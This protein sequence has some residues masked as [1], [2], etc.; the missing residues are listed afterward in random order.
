MIYSA[1]RYVLW[2]YIEG[3]AETRQFVL[4]RRRGAFLVS[5]YKETRF[6]GMCQNMERIKHVR[7]WNAL[8]H[9]D[10]AAPMTQR[11]N[12]SITRHNICPSALRYTLARDVGRTLYVSYRVCMPSRAPPVSILISKP[13]DTYIVRYIKISKSELAFA[14]RITYT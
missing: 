2:I 7:L 8:N 9:R 12:K 6:V 10:S 5:T 13:G 11:N 4:A 14:S 1:V 3:D